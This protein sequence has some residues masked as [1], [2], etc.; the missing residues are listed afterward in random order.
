MTAK[1]VAETDGAPPVR[2]PEERRLRHFDDD[3]QEEQRDGG[4]RER[5]ELA[6][7]V[8]MIRVGRFLCEP[9]ADEGDDV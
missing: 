5:L 3:H 2:K 1:L 6:M 8:G 7:A 9:Q 4:G